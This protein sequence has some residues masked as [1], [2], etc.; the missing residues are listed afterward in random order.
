MKTNKITKFLSKF[1]I[2]IWYMVAL[3]LFFYSGGRTFLDPEEDP[4]A[5]LIFWGII[6]IYI[7]LKIFQEIFSQITSLKK[8]VEKLSKKETL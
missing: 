1:W 7:N 2:E 8:E 4:I 5:S 3:F 6:L